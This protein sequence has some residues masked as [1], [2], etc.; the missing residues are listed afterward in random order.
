MKLASSVLP[1]V[2]VKLQGTKFSARGN[3]TR[4]GLLFDLS[5]SDWIFMNSDLNTECEIKVRHEI[6]G[7]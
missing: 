1:D 4:Q 5:N 3:T 7:T 2:W 6:Y